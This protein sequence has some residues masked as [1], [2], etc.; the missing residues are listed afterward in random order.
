M[1]SILLM[2]FLFSLKVIA[3][4]LQQSKHEIP[5]YYLTVEC[6]MDNIL[7]LRKE[8]NTAYEKEGVKL[9]V[10]D[11]IIKATALASKRVPGK[12]LCS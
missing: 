2:A 7:K 8:I 10:N 6:N 9:S 3:K 1:H 11:F 4:R 5:H 12:F